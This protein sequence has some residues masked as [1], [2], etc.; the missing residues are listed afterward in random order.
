MDERALV[1]R[2]FDAFNRRDADGIAAVCDE[3][4]EFFPVPPRRSGRTAPYTA[5]RACATT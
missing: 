1:E 5:P 2:L 4:M 3:E